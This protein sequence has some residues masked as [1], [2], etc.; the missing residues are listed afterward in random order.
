MDAA[1]DHAVAAGC[2][3]LWLITTN[4]NTRALRFYQLWGMDLCAFYR[5]GARLSRTAKPSLPKQGADGI[6][7]E[8]E[9]E[10][11]LLLAQG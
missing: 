9:L 3:R 5:H 11:E 10:L 6:P 4:D 1:H 8:H 2:R 7:L